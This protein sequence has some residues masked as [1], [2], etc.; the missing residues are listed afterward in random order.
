IAS[1]PEVST[2]VKTQKDAIELA[3]SMTTK[4]VKL[5]HHK[6]QKLSKRRGLSPRQMRGLN[7]CLEMVSETLDELGQV[8][9]DLEEYDTKKSIK[10]HAEDLKTLMSSAITDQE[11]C[12]DG[13]SQ[14]KD[15]K[16]AGVYR[17]NVEVPKGKTNIMFMGDG[18]NNTIITASRSVK[19]TGHTTFESATVECRKRGH[20][21]VDA[22]APPK[23]LR[24][25]HAG[26]RPTESTRG[27]KS[28]AAI[29][30][31]I[32]SKGAAAAG[33]P[34]S[35]NTSFASMVG[36]PES[37][38]RPEW[39]ITNGSMLDT[40][41][42]CQNLVD[43]VVPPGYFLE[44]RHLHNDDFLRQY[45][46]SNDRLS[47]QVSTLQEQVSGEEKLKAAFEEFKQYEDNQVE[48]RCAEMDAR[49]D[50]LS[51]DFDEELYPHM[52]TAIVGR[53][54]SASSVPVLL[55]S[56][57]LCTRRVGSAH[58]ARSDGVPVSVPTVVPQGLAILLADA[59]TQTKSDE[60]SQLL[61][62]SSLSVMHS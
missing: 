33:D 5:S 9:K 49:L 47:Q 13:F 55:K 53:S 15:D 58:H 62:S 44:L 41:K 29:E 21:G 52:L 10:Q 43:H 31:G 4:A 6:I 32:S 24:R 48:Q 23:V 1:H 61:R 35:E 19:G 37:L 38:Y 25:D 7:D 46:V 20:D 17:E 60:A 45:N 8:T 30:L 40:Q 14:D 26:P 3:V 27:G 39:G 12:L 42:A 56:R 11:T 57:S 50:A 36:S 59:A 22:N 16:K 51:I 2:K 28:L 18:R 34:E 54:G